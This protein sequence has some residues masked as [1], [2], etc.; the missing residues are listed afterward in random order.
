M[1]FAVPAD[2]K[3]KLKE[4]EKD[5]YLDLPRELKKNN[6]K[7]KNQKKNKKQTN[8][9]QTLERESDIYTNYN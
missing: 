7:T 2:H 4:N 1:D 9:K 3:V 5:K 6:K 8:K